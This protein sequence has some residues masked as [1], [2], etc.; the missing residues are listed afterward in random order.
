MSAVSAIEP[1]LRRTSLAVAP[2]VLALASIATALA[3]F[4]YANT[5]LR[6]AA[7]GCGLVVYLYMLLTSDNLTLKGVSVFLLLTAIPFALLTAF[8]SDFRSIVVPF[9][10]VSSVGISW[11]AFEQ[12]CTRLIFELPFFLYLA[13]TAYL[14]VVAG[15]GPAE[16]ND[17][18]AGIGRNGY[19]AILVALTCGYVLSRSLQGRDPSV[20]VLLLAFALSFP[21]YGRSS[22]TALAIVA[23]S[24][25]LLRWP[26][27]TLAILAV[28]AT[29]SAWLTYELSDLIQTTTNFKAGLISDRWQ[30]LDEYISA[31]NPLT[32]LTGV[33]M[34]NLPA[35]VE[36]D[37]SPDISVLRLHSYLGLPSVFFFVAIV[38]SGWALLRDRRYL[39]LGVFVAIL[40][41][42][43]T[44][45]I[46]L[47]GTVDLF[48]I[49][50]I[51]FP[52]YKR[53][54]T[55]GPSRI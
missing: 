32:A 55:D 12:R 35:V 18:F 49:P 40:F 39:I 45:I 19:S 33:D 23:A 24:C 6:L 48:F 15:Y 43:L 1:A 21:L 53:Y 41:R 47:F 51:L 38:S 14:V 17:F 37:G 46:L 7:I 13:L 27:L 52:L 8:R 3:A 10:F 2:S 25:G 5:P 16:F 11:F 26:K 42:S 20:V 28:G 30:I 36:N 9:C 31:L 50:A 22:I 54:W 29:A 44:D 4:Y 34:R